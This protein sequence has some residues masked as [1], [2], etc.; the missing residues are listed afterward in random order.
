MDARTLNNARYGKNIAGSELSFLQKW[1]LYKTHPTK[2]AI[3]LTA[4]LWSVYFLWDH[5]WQPALTIYLIVPALSLFMVKDLNLEKFAA[6]TLGKV[7]ILHLQPFNLL[8]QSVSI[9]VMIYGIWLHST[10]WILGGV[11]LLFVGHIFG[12]QSV[13][14]SLTTDL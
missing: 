3:D 1:V 14:D 9:L 8:I 6:T 7:A 10:E 13:H 5:R 4:A 11:S 2:V 12:W